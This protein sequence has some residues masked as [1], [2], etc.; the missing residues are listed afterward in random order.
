MWLTTGR[1]HR[2]RKQYGDRP[3]SV[4]LLGSRDLQLLTLAISTGVT[5]SSVQR[6]RGFIAKEFCWPGSLTIQHVVCTGILGAL[7]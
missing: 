2:L 5:F 6:R 3:A 1:W 7:W 4:C